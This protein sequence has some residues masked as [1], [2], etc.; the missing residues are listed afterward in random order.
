MQVFGLSAPAEKALLCAIESSW[1]HLY[2]LVCLDSVEF[3]FI[4]WA[5]MDQSLIEPSASFY[6]R[7]STDEVVFLFLQCFDKRSRSR[8]SHVVSLFKEVLRMLHKGGIKGV[9]L[10]KAIL[11]FLELT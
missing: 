6:G 2:A 11:N 9:L 1:S 8:R 4:A 3:L 7:V 5:I 10:V